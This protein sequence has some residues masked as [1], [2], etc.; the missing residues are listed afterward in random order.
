VCAWFS[1][2]FRVGAICVFTVRSTAGSAQ[3]AVQLN[4][5]SVF[6]N[7]AI[8]SRLS[9]VILGSGSLSLDGADNSYLTLSNA[10]AFA[11]GT[12]WALR[13]GRSAAS[14]GRSRHGDGGA[15]RRRRISFGSTTTSPDSV[16]LLYGRQRGFCRAAGSESASLCAQHGGGG[17]MSLYIDG[18][19]S[20]NVTAA[21]TIFYIDTLWL[22]YPTNDIHYSFKRP[23]GRCAR[24]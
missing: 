12:P 20:T 18:E 19:F 8:E 10:L 15:D 17:Q 23:A 22:A 14:D 16:P 4:R 6:G 1:R 11:N 21:N 2:C 7:A 24:L 5:V 3:R 9:K 13:S